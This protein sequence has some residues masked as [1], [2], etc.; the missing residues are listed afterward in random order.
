MVLDNSGS[1]GV[2]NKMEAMKSAAIGLV[3]TLFGNEKTPDNIKIGLVPFMGAVNVGVSS[4]TTWLDKVTP[5]PL[6]SQYLNLDVSNGQSAFTVLESM[7][8]GIAANWDG[9]VRSRYRFEAGIDDLDITDTPPT[10]LDPDTLF[11]AYFYPFMDANIALYQGASSNTQNDGCPIAPIQP[12]TNNKT[13]ITDAINAMYEWGGTNI[14]EALSWGWRVIS[15]GEPFTEGQA[16]SDPHT[17]K[18]IILLTDGD[19]AINNNLFSSYGKPHGSPTNPQLGAN[20]DGTLDTKTSQVCT[21]I[22][23]DLDGDPTDTDILIYSI[24]FNV[25]ASP[26]ITLMQNCATTV[27]KHYFN[28]PSAQDLDATFQTIAASLNQLRIK[29]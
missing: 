29:Q 19:N 22:K 20:V 14:P 5:A 21:N 13:T 27:S 2:G 6:N 17:I 26:I 7:S 1:M 25:N 9:C 12:L 18:A 28:S 11:S 4:D 24:V 3:D 16:Y 15:P 23:A 10:A 8:G